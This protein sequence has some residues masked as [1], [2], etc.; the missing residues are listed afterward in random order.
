MSNEAGL[1]EEIAILEWKKTLRH[2]ASLQ[3]QE[4]DALPKVI[5]VTYTGGD[6][7]Y[8][9]SGR[10]RAARRN[11]FRFVKGTPIAVTEPEDIKF[12]MNENSSSFSVEVMDEAKIAEAEAIATQKAADDAKARAEQ[13]KAE[14]ELLKQK[15]KADVKA[16]KDAGKAKAKAEKAKAKVEAKDK[17]EAKAQATLKAKAE[18]EAVALEAQASKKRAEAGDD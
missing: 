15:I 2:R 11:P 10:S 7:Q 8:M 5:Y 16:L 17:A 6:N 9:H 13:V 3:Q 1:N 12:F 14:Q 18:A 4:F